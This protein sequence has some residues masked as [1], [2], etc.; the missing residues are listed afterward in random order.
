MKRK[1]G[2]TIGIVDNLD[3]PERLG[4]VRVTYPELDEES[5]WARLVTLMAGPDR[6]AFFRPEEGDEVAVM[7][8][9]GDPRRPYILGALWNV[10]DPPPPNG[11][12]PTDNHLRL[13]KS[14]SGHIVRFDD[15]PGEEKIEIV[16][17]DGQRQV[18]VDSANQKIQVICQSGDVEVTANSGTVKVEA[19]TVELTASG[20]MSL[21]AG[22]T[23]NIK[24]NL[25]KINS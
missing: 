14:R 15:T 21:K 2:I 9:H 6:G 17:K 8:E 4:R 3:D 7:F 10:E 1:Q 25:V 12:N 19:R 23:M 11:D 16:D 18:I 24:G 5:Y 13:I 22:G 20:N